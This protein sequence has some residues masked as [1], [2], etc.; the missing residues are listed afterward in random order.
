M[1]ANAHLQA[2][3]EQRRADR[4]DTGLPVRVGGGSGRTHNI[5]A[6]GIYFETDTRQE[7][8]SL[9]NF[10]VEFTLNGRTHRLL[11]EGKVVRVEPRG[12]RVGVAA[13][14]LAPLFDEDSG[15]GA[16]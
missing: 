15:P 14:L 10:T 7:P 1:A 12:D 11:C 13:R 6:H 16:A 4:F 3:R 8:G 2:G 9:V 5:S